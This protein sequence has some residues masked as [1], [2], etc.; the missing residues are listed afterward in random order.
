MMGRN[1]DTTRRKEKEQDGPY[2]D[3]FQYTWAQIPNALYALTTSPE[4]MKLT[5]YSAITS[6][7]HIA[8]THMYNPDTTG[9][10]KNALTARG[11]E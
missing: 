8:G 11:P 7:M 4:A 1:G 5:D 3:Q 2:K 9:T 6:S 10:T